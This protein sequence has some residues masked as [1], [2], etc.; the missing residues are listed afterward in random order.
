MVNFLTAN[1][2]FWLDMYHFDGL[3]VDGVESMI[4]LDFGRKPGE[5]QPNKFGGNENLAAIEFLK[6]VNRKVHELFPGTLTIAEDATARP[7]ITRP[8]QSVGS[9]ST[10]SGTWAGSTTRSA[11]TCR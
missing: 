2:L 11:N 5:W 10:T 8:A 1:A 3:R 9:A 6:R 4:R 7:D